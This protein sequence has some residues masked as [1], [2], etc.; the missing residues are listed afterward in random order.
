MLC[1][2]CTAQGALR[3]NES[4]SACTPQGKP[5]HPS[6]ALDLPEKRPLLLIYTK[7][8]SLAG[9]R[10]VLEGGRFF[11]GDG[12]TPVRSEPTF[13]HLSNSWVGASREG[14]QENGHFV[15]SFESLGSELDSHCSE[16]LGSFFI[17]N[18]VIK[19][20]SSLLI[21]WVQ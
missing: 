3:Q 19:S 14:D 4:K 15:P 17:Y 7:I 16:T 11:L 5:T 13:L 8:S 18:M 10:L 21:T 12:S 6:A 2:S 1:R 9:S 20:P